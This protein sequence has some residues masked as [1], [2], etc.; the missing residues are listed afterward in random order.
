MLCRSTEDMKSQGQ[1]NHKAD[2]A[3]DKGPTK[4]KNK[5]LEVLHYFAFFNVENTARVLWCS[6]VFFFSKVIFA[7][8]CIWSVKYA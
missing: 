8:K 6:D 7:S 1:I 4:D 5:A 3:K 2:K